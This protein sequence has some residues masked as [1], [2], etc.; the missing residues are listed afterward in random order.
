MRVFVTLLI[1]TWLVLPGAAFAQTALAQAGPM[2]TEVRVDGNQR[3]ESE[4]IFSYLE[5][6][7]GDQFDRAL[8][9][10]SLKDLFDTGLFADVTLVQEGST[11]IVRVVE[12]PIINRIAFEGNDKL[13]DDNL[14]GEIQLRPRV[15]YTR[16]KVQTDVK[17]ILEIY[18]AGGRFA[19]TVEPKVISLPE[20]RVD[21]VFEIDEGEVT[22]VDRI[23]FVGNKVFDD[24]DL[25]GVVETEETA[26]WKFLTSSDTYDP[27]RLNFDKELLRRYYLANGYADFRVVSAV[28]ELV[29]NRQ[30]FFI[31]YTVEEGERYKFGTVDIVSELRD[32]D[33]EAVREA[34]Q[35]EPDDWY[36]ADLVEATVDNLTDEVGNLGYAFVDVR[37]QVRR[38]RDERKIDITFEV[39]EGPRVFVERINISGNT[40]TLDKVIR[41]EIQ[42]IE[43]DAFNT[44]QL[45]R[46]QQR[47]QNLGFFETVEVNNVPGD[48]P[49]KTVVEVEVE[50]KSTGEL[51]LGAGFS[52]SEG[53]I[54]DFGIHEKNLLG[55]G[56][57]LGLTFTISGRT[58]EIDL[59]F[60]EPYFLDRN[61]SA[62]VDLFRVSKDFEDEAGF[63]QRSTGFNLR[64]GY[65]IAY[66]LNQ[67]LKYGF[68]RDEVRN[69]DSTASRFVREQEGITYASVVSQDL[70]YDR[71]NSR[72]DPTE[73]YFAKLGHDFAG[74]GGDVHYLRNRVEGGKYFTLD[75]DLTLTLSA[76]AGYIHG[77]DDTVRINDRF[78]LG[79]DDLRGFAIAGVGPRDLNTGDSLGGDWFYAGTTELSFPIGLPSE[80]G[81]FG[82]AFTD[83][84]SV[85]GSQET[86][87]LID[88]SAALRASVGIGLGWSSPFGPVRVDYGFPV[89][90][91]EFDKTEALRISF[92]TSF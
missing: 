55:K 85:G 91:Q 53:P 67:Q 11:V 82:K 46:S 10:K 24:S 45:R 58:Q 30:G 21:L 2:V 23:N 68:S 43:G 19:A 8:M 9:D 36:N 26:W 20:N 48:A 38:E 40:R 61:M 44:A 54:G 92:G 84:G 49:D 90:K 25:R 51:S 35:M 17:R 15:V 41:R 69:V 5:V 27:D 62:G 65:T 3:I 73:G 80:L 86:G 6:K 56:Q 18:R 39:S 52:S 29:P 81:I 60:T 76:E 50:E 37:P 74:L 75:E 59:S 1:S 89:L 22:A 33:P 88:T 83:F 14:S 42:L 77:L 72:F 4:T 13:S 71:R 70:L 64:T 47:L 57:D 16:T 32:L 28:A 66:P 79:G 87:P 7:P 63:D 34:V 78:F 12:N 31:T